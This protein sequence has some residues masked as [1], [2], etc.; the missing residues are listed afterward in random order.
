MSSATAAAPR[1]FAAE[2]AADFL[3]EIHPD[4]DDDH[5][6][7]VTMTVLCAGQH[8]ADRGYPG[9]WEHLDPSSFLAAMAACD[10]HELVGICLDLAGLYGWLGANQLIAPLDA[11][12]VLAGVR[13]AGPDAPIL[14]SLCDTGIAMLEQLATTVPTR[15]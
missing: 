9:A 5:R 3:D 7:R 1:Y 15:N 4:F 2:L 6:D 10:H 13:A 12:A 14:R 11:A 8:L